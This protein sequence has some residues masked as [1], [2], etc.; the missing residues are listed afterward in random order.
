LVT[1]AISAIPPGLA[2]QLAPDGVLVA[3]IG[4][5]AGAQEI[6]RAVR[7]ADGLASTAFGRARVEPAVAGV[8][9]RL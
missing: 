7:G 1:C 8:T 6:V 9:R 5:G 2:S 3:P 4:G